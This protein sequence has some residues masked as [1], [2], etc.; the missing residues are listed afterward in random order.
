M[1]SLR[2]L[3]VVSFLG[4]GLGQAQ[5]EFVRVAT[6]LANPRGVVVL[7][8]Y[9]LYVVE[10]GH[11]DVSEGTGRISHFIDLNKDGDFD[12]PEEMNA[13]LNKIP[14][15]NGLTMF[16]T[17]HD[18]VGGLSDLLL[19]DEQLIFSKDNPQ[20]AYLADG[21]NNDIGLQELSLEG[22]LGRTLL[23]RDF[24]LNSFTYDPKSKFFYVVE[25]GN[26]ALSRFKLG[27]P[28]EYVAAFLPLVSAQQAVPAGVALEPT[29]GDLFVALFSGQVYNGDLFESYKENEAKIVRVNPETLEQTDELTDLT[30]VVDLVATKE[31]ILYFLELSTGEPLARL[32]RD[33]ELSDPNA[34]PLAGGYP[35]KSG[36]LSMYDLKTKKTTILLEG[37]DAPTNLSYFEGSLYIS[38]GQGTPNRLVTA[39]DGSV[40]PIVGELYKVTGLS[41]LFD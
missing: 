40:F 38:T 41:A 32:A 23:R 19:L 14:S 7:S 18:E 1:F 13:L 28:F 33:F 35:R 24:T 29:S 2:I 27:E 10:A 8:D 17:G 39:P 11:G 9:E 36:R 21:S 37:L 12:D 25:S 5:L 16:G 22:R 3:I 31:G 4:L 15:Y 26:N 6:N 20:A 34:L 30:T